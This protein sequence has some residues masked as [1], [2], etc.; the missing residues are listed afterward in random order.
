MMKP[1]SANQQSEVSSIEVLKTIHEFV[2]GDRPSTNRQN[3]R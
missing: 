1:N 2:V 3:T